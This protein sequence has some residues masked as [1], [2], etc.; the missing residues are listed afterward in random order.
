MENKKK[1]LYLKNVFENGIYINITHSILIFAIAIYFGASTHIKISYDGYLYL[2]SAQS[3]FSSE[4]G[5]WYHWIREPGYPLFLRLF[6]SQDFDFSNIII[7]QSLLLAISNSFVFYYFQKISK[8]NIVR[9]VYFISSLF[10]FFLAIG[11]STWIL[12]Q[13]MFIFVFSL[14]I[15]FYAHTK[16][17]SEYTKTLT[18]EASVIFLTSALISVI[19]IP[20]SASF[21]LYTLIGSQ[22]PKLLIFKKLISIMVPCLIFLTIW[23]IFKIY[24]LNNS[25]K[26]YAEQEEILQKNFVF[27]YA[28][29]PFRELIYSAPSNLGGIMGITNERSGRDTL[30]PLS[31]HLFF[32]FSNNGTDMQCQLLLEGP[33][34]I[35]DKL[36]ILEISKCKSNNLFELYAYLINK[37]K[38]ILPSVLFMSILMLLN[39]LKNRDKY[40]YPICL[41]VAVS[42]LPYL[43]EVYGKSRY[44]LVFIFFTP[45]LY[46]YYFTS[47]LE[48]SNKLKSLK[49]YF[50][51]EK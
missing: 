6:Y 27:E 23:N 38:W 2:S 39:A 12:Q 3:L 13:V 22:K 45:Y 7:A 36:G 31:N 37:I 16:F 49:N 30:E 15:L 47:F 35:I 11:Y 18:A 44:G 26:I 20:A 29:A 48:N 50:F 24:E 17:R 4:L 40:I 10:S 42:V 1:V 43:L 14:H 46:A 25:E 8:R 28:D 5:D 21:I 51:S 33:K 9:I 32:A 34:E 41:Y 19:L